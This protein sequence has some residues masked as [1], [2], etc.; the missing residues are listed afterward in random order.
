METLGPACHGDGRLWLGEG[1]GLLGGVR[2]RPL[3]RRLHDR[4]ARVDRQLRGL[5]RAGRY[6]HHGEQ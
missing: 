5:G 3:H 1:G 2:A 6:A 4:V